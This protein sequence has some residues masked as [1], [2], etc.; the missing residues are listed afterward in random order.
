MNMNMNMTQY[1]QD[2][3]KEIKNMKSYFD[4]GF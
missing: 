2:I 4:P 1:Q 3:L